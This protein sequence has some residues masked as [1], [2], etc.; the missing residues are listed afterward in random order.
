MT[1]WRP[2]ARP[3][4]PCSSA[5]RA[6][7]PSI[8]CTCPKIW[9]AGTAL[10]PVRNRSMNSS[11]PITG[12]S[13]I[14][15]RARGPPFP[16]GFRRRSASRHSVASRRRRQSH[17][18]HR[19]RRR[20]GPGRVR[21]TYGKRLAFMGGLDK[22]VLRRSR[23]EIA[24]ELERKIPPMVQTGGCVLGLDHRIPGGTPLSHY[25][26]YIEKAWEII[27]RTRGSAQS[28]RTG[29]VPTHP[30]GKS[31]GEPTERRQRTSRARSSRE[32]PQFRR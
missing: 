13:G 9:P 3:P 14:C 7:S 18:P 23:Q 2:S 16:P 24:A 11:A 17:L 4:L 6:R 27:E 21:R 25:R 31:S 8:N 22:H 10:C 26:F 32:P 5:S 1:F 28:A 19:A 20:H 29:Q 15:S 30:P 12:G